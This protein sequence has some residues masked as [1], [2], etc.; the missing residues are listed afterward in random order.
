MVGREDSNLR[1][2]GP[3]PDACLA[4][5][6]SDES[7]SGVYG[8]NPFSD[9]EKSPYPNPSKAEMFHA[10]ILSGQLNPPELPHEYSE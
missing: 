7:V 2:P 6:I 10:E 4:F 3:Q 1:P 5:W 8:K 9:I